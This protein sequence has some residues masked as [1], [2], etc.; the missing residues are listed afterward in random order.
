V[1][2]N[3]TTIVAAAILAAVGCGLMGGIFFAFSNF[4]MQALAQQSPDSGIRTM[5]AINIKI[6][7]PLFL[8]IFIGTPLCSVFLVAVSAHRL[9]R[10]GAKLL[11][12]GAALYLVGAL[13]VTVAFNIPLN[14]R[15]AIQDP[16]SADATQYWLAYVSEWM[17][18]NHTRTI[19]SLAAAAVL[20]LAIRQICSPAN[21]A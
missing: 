12:S 21:Q 17:K 6:V 1:E 18:W 4:V 13:A 19:A 5:Q 14:D 20:V 10:P 16:E 2:L 11:L 15:L 3:K 8:T 7:N 9:S